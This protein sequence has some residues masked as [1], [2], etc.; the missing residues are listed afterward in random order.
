MTRECLLPPAD[1]ESVIAVGRGDLNRVDQ[2]VPPYA[3]LGQVVDQIQGATDSAASHWCKSAASV[4][5]CSASIVPSLLSAPN[6]ALR[7]PQLVG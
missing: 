1:R 3:P 7:Q 4:A 6:T 2:V 5:S